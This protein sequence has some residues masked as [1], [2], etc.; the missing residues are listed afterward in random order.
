MKLV[1]VSKV[2]VELV[3]KVL[4]SEVSKSEKMR[5]MFSLGVSVSEISK[6]LEVRYQFV[7]NIVSN[8]IIKEKLEVSYDKKVS[9]LVKELS[10]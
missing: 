3:K 8:Y 7:N 9:E 1:G 5:K 6:L 4:V 10:K 2:D